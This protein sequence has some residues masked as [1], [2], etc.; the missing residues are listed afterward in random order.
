[1]EQYRAIAEAI[2]SYDGIVFD[3]DGTLVDLRVDWHNAKQSLSEYCEQKKGVSIEFTPLD[4]K[5]FEMRMRFGASFF[6]SLLDILA[7]YELHSEN[8]VLNDRLI[9]IFDAIQREKKVAIYSMNTEVCV[10]SFSDKFLRRKPDRIISKNTC[11]E[12]KP[13]A[14]DLKR[15]EKGWGMGCG[16]IFYVGNS[17]FDRISGEE[18]GIKTKIISWTS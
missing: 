6:S 18:A 13:T 8:Y 15:I 12:P 7:T 5:I 16:Q 2:V 3:L 10:R 1:M 17:E 4:E 11:L 9:Q 14:I